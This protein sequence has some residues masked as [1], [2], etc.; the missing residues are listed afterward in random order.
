MGSELLEGHSHPLRL[1]GMGSGSP[2]KLMRE[3]FIIHGSDE[4]SAQTVVMVCP[5]AGHHG[6]VSDTAHRQPAYSSGGG[7][8]PRCMLCRA[9]R[10]SLP[11]CRAAGVQ[12]GLLFL[13]LRSYRQPS[14]CLLAACVI[15]S[16]RR[17][18]IRCCREETC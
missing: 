5:I 9:A 11:H 1:Y 13:S 15:P 10:C 3:L 4:G 6:R 12:P 8:A 16:L 17:A 7:H 2:S 18:C 14:V